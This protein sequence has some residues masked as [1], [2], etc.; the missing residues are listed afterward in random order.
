MRDDFNV[1]ASRNE[2]NASWH[3]FNPSGNSP[4]LFKAGMRANPETQSLDKQSLK[5]QNQSSPLAV[6]PGI[7]TDLRKSNRR[8]SVLPS[9]DDLGKKTPHFVRRIFFAA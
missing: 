8:E 6:K 4:P 9:L 7:S 3:D 5:L 1:G 2:V